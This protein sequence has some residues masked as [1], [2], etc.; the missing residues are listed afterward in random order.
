MGIYF[1]P[2]D[3]GKIFHIK[4]RDGEIIKGRLIDFD[5]IIKISTDKGEHRF[6]EAKIEEVYLIKEN[7]LDSQINF[8]KTPI[9]EFLSILKNIKL[10]YKSIS[11]KQLKEELLDLKKD[12][13]L[14]SLYLELQ[15]IFNSLKFAYEN[16]Q[17]DFKYDKTNRLLY[18][19]DNLYND[20][21]DELIDKFIVFILEH[22]KT[23]Y[24]EFFGKEPEP[25]YYHILVY[26]MHYFY[27][28]N[29][30]EKSFLLAT[31]L[32]NEFFLSEELK[33]EWLVYV[34]S[35]FQFKKIS[36]IETQLSKFYNE[37][38]DEMKEILKYSILYLIY[39][40]NIPLNDL[41][42]EY[43][44]SIGTLTKKELIEL[45]NVLEIYINSKLQNEEYKIEEVKRK[46]DKFLNDFEYLKAYEYIKGISKFFNSSEFD[47][48]YNEIS[49]YYK[50]WIIFK[51]QLPVGESVNYIKAKK[52]QLIEKNY[53]KAKFYFELSIDEK[54]EKFQSAIKDYIQ[55]SRTYK[56]E[57]TVKLIEKYK[58]FFTHEEK[59]KFNNLVLPY[60]KEYDKHL[61]LQTINQLLNQ[62]DSKDIWKKKYQKI[63]GQYLIEAAK[64]Y[65]EK[66]ENS[67]AV[68]YLLKAERLESSDK[69][70]CNRLIAHNYYK[71][72]NIEEAK[73][74][75]KENIEK[76]AD[77]ESV[78]LLNEMKN[79]ILDTSI[80]KID[81]SVSR[82]D[83]EEFI[84]M[85]IK[86]CKFVGVSSTKAR[87]KNFT[88][89]DLEDVLNLDNI[90]SAQEK[91]ERLLTA[92][93][94]SK[95]LKKDNNVNN[96]LAKSLRFY[97]NYYISQNKFDIGKNFLLASLFMKYKEEVLVDYFKVIIENDINREE[98]I[99]LADYMKNL[100]IND[101]LKVGLTYIYFVIPS[102]FEKLNISEK[103]IEKEIEAF[104][105][106]KDN[107]NLLKTKNSLNEINIKFKY[108][109][110][111]FVDREFF[112]NFE[113]ILYL[114]KEYKESNISSFSDNMYILEKIF[115]K[116]NNLKNDI[117][118]QLTIFGAVLLEIIENLI[119]QINDEIE[120]LKTSKTAILYLSSPIEKYNKDENIEFHLS[121]YN[122]KDL[123]DAFI[124][125]IKI[126]DEE[127]IVENIVPSIRIKGGENKTIPIPLN[128]KAKET[129]SIKVKVTY[130]SCDEIKEIESSFS[131]N[132]DDSEF[133]PI[134]NPYTP[135]GQIVKDKK[136]FFG[137]DE[138]M[139]NLVKQFKDDKIQALVLYG[140][141]RVGKSTVFHYLEEELSNEFFVINITSL[142]SVDE[143]DDFMEL[144]KSSIE[145]KFDE[146]FDEDIYD[147]FD[148]FDEITYKNIEKLLR[149]LKKYLLKKELSLLVL[150]DEFTY[151]YEKI[152]ENKMDATILR[153]LKSLLQ[154]N[155]I[156]L[157][158]I[159]QNS[160][161]LFIN[162]YPN[163]LAVFRKVKISYLDKKASFE[164]LENPILINGKSRYKDDS[165]QYIYEL[166]NG[167]PFY[168]QKIGFELV[169]YLNKKRFN[170]ITRA[171]IEEIINKMFENISL[172]GE[173]DNII[174]LGNGIYKEFENLRKEAILQIAKKSK[175]YGSVDFD[176]IDLSCN[177]DRKREI[178]QSLVDTDVVDVIH[179]RYSLKVKLLEKYIQNKLGGM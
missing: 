117:N 2:E 156:K 40:F 30:L 37:L 56:K 66:G 47:K 19:L 87:I 58:H 141:K 95:T 100:K 69:I 115:N 137:R 154:Q 171:T 111:F 11:F 104:K 60:I 77:Q 136:M 57:D 89:K 129:F 78:M 16:N 36:P 93:V 120:E 94:I 70:L 68:N 130:E 88:E 162:D 163:E 112:K 102:I 149:D 132:V 179:N 91:A 35:V 12:S 110:L 145:N 18:K 24:T 17:M 73:K 39:K 97:A 92:F 178:I 21:D 96:Y 159:G 44:K 81:N 27:K 62:I 174:S 86:Q 151:L 38:S 116:L 85:Y 61:Y 113:S 52:A 142:G 74:Y 15:N 76:F 123:A 168:L 143:V 101:E 29:K 150:I 53:K 98:K 99:R 144:L 1:E 165:L 55:M 177:D 147:I 133:I 72:N 9:S 46:V 134:D 170:Y 139:S 54:E 7:P 119:K 32:F 105:E 3:I 33:N 28:K 45:I 127:E 164:L 126:Y 49:G 148:Y 155:L 64:V 42:R 83:I 26:D 4:K 152:K 131:I 109:K 84:N 25:T 135:D 10:E 23:S 114:I 172:E 63:Y 106:I 14:H 79:D 41:Q 146:V 5:P 71:I 160:M 108:E 166:T 51:D 31:I 176:S 153:L 67:K 20:W 22:N 158:V 48:L 6:L 103:V 140:Q 80:F 50:N 128:I 175:I 121:I 161:P 122:E 8:S 59:I 169:E 157:G 75:L 167:S 13:E 43:L 118:N 107:L 173:F 138:L 124:N 82:I 34:E 125:S 90:K 65:T